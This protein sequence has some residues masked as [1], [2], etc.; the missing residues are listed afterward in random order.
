[1]LKKI[2]KPLI[3]ASLRWTLRRQYLH[4]RGWRYKGNAVYC[5]CC[6]RSYSQFLP[7]TE[8]ARKRPDVVCPG[9]AVVERH[10]LLILFLKNRV[11]SFNC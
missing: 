2:L 10:R 11:K 7:M 1:M 3:P 5:P 9:C 8:G 6:K 4:F